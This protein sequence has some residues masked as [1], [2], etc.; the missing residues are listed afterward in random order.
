[1]YYTT[2][3]NPSAWIVESKDKGRKKIYLNSKIYLD[4]GSEFM[5]ELF[6]PL[7]ESVLADIKINGKN[8]ASTGLILRPG[9]RFYL[10]CFVDDRKKFIF[11]TYEVENSSEALGAISN[12]G[13]VEISFFKEKIIRNIYNAGGPIFDGHGTYTY[14]NLDMLNVVPAS[15]TNTSSLSTNS[16]SSTPLSSYNN[17]ENRYNSFNSKRFKTTLS[18][19]SI[20]TGRIEKGTASQQKFE[21]VDMDFETICLTKVSYQLLPESKRPIETT[22]I[23]K[24][25]NFCS[26]CGHK[27][28]GTEKFCPSC[29][30]RI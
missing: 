20:E 9:Q 4:N 14:T 16:L 22:E 5:I 1:M 24:T 10:D 23:K 13:Y 2:T 19:K 8:A 12:N 25:A 17:A 11:K 28:K 30:T 26:N 6:N 18:S 15:Y 7:S 3:T 27:L 21:S 29:G